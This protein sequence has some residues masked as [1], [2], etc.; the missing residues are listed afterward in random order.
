MPKGSAVPKP[1][2]D[3]DR[4]RPRHPGA[5]PDRGRTGVTLG[6]AGGHRGAG[7]RLQAV[8]DE[9]RDKTGRY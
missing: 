7:P 3:P 5:R 8:Y 9:A 6:R 4:D 1:Y 2:T